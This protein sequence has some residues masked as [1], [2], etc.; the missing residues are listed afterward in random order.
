LRE[1]GGVLNLFQRKAIDWYRDLL[2]VK[3]ID[4]TEDEIEKL[5]IERSQARKDKNWQRADEIRNKLFEKGIILEDKLDKT[6]WKVK[7]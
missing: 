7:I 3:K 5:I 6:V 4:I 1:I 2:K